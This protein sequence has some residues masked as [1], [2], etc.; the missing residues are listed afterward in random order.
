[1]CATSGSTTARSHHGQVYASRYLFADTGEGLVQS[2]HQ[3]LAPSEQAEALTRAGH[4][5]GRGWIQTSGLGRPD[6]VV[7]IRGEA[8][9]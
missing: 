2:Y 5:H 4:V 9:A 8:T 7:D 6:R 1:M 3:T